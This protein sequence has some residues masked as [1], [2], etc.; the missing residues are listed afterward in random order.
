MGGVDYPS[1]GQPEDELSSGQNMTR[2]QVGDR[3]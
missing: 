3:A 1:V 2:G